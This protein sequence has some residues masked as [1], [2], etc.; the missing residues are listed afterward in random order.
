MEDHVDR[1]TECISS[2]MQMC[3]GSPVCHLVCLLFLSLKTKQVEGRSKQRIDYFRC[4]Q[5]P[6]SKFRYIYVKE[7]MREFQILISLIRF[8]EFIKSSASLIEFLCKSAGTSLTTS[9]YRNFR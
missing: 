1:D 8:N 7:S 6:F 2:M 4:R 9:L 5:T 3:K